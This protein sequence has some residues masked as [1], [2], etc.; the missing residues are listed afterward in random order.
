MMPVWRVYFPDDGETADDARGL[1]PK[2]W[3]RIFD[4]KDAAAAAC[5]LDYGDR[6]GWERG[7]EN[8]FKITIIAEDGS[9]TQWKGWS[10]MTVEHKAEPISGDA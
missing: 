6:D 7:M 2:P 1:H 3:S 9:E 10:E 5:E 8:R 4:A